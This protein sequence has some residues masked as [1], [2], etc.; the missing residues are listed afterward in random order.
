VAGSKSIS[1]YGKF[2]S[3]LKNHPD[4]VNDSNIPP[5]CDGWFLTYTNKPESRE[6]LE[7]EIDTYSEDAFDK[8]EEHSWS[9]EE[10]NEIE[11]RA[12]RVTRNKLSNKYPDINIIDGELKEFVIDSMQMLR[13]R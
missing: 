6:H 8:S 2:L 9:R 12:I 10:L 11:E 1:D 13:L 7:G 3:M 4:A 5:I